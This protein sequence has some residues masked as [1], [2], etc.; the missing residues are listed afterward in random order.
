MKP[1]IASFLALLALRLCNGNLYVRITVRNQSPVLLRIANG[2][3]SGPRT[4]ASNYCY[5]MP[6][7][8]RY[9]TSQCVI[10]LEDGGYNWEGARI[11]R[12]CPGTGNN[13]WSR[14]IQ[15]AG[16]NPSQYGSIGYN[17]VKTELSLDLELFLCD[18]LIDYISTYVLASMHEI[19]FAAIGYP[20]MTTWAFSGNEDPNYSH[21]RCRNDQNRLYQGEAMDCGCNV[22]D[23]NGPTSSSKKKTSGLEAKCSRGGRPHCPCVVDASLSHNGVNKDD[24][25]DQCSAVSQYVY[26]A[27]WGWFNPKPDRFSC[28]YKPGRHS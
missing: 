10:S 23:Y 5:L 8:T 20:K 13:G 24:A 3:S 21:G 6:R 4:D 17:Y 9:S 7:D 15:V 12:F 28:C 1:A 27:A 22:G 25:R 11:E 19:T 2:R 26:L 14:V 16:W 18:I